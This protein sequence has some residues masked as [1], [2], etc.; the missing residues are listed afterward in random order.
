[1]KWTEIRS[2]YAECYSRIR[3]DTGATQVSVAEA[4]GLAQ[5]TISKLLNNDRRGPSV[6]TFVAAVAGLGMSV[7]EFFQGIEG[8]APPAPVHTAE[9]EQVVARLVGLESIVHALLS[10]FAPSLSSSLSSSSSTSDEA[11]GACVA[12]AGGVA[13]G[14]H[15]I[16][17]YISPS[18]L[19]LAGVAALLEAAH[20][21][22]VARAN[23]GVGGRSGSDGISRA[24]GGAVAARHVGRSRQN[25]KTA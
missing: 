7:S 21:A 25:K 2:H 11:G 9:Y 23:Q 13:Y 14:D 22:A 24:G 15:S 8:H 20:S 19:E 3:R 18:G 10:S 17:R 4:G 1:M 12:G 16:R 5:N 6:E